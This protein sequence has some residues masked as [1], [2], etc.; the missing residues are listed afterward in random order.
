MQM[1][2]F[3]MH[4]QGLGNG[5]L[6]TQENAGSKLSQYPKLINQQDPGIDKLSMTSCVFTSKPGSERKNIR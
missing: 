1:R 4:G 5:T 2:D 6:D 3:M